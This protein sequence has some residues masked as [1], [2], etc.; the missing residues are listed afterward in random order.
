M[1][2][3]PVLIQV[4][5]TK[6]VYITEDTHVDKRILFC[7]IQQDNKNNN[8][9]NNNKNKLHEHVFLILYYCVSV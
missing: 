9:N 3:P 2:F 6:T 4:S 1:T 5:Y 7:I 8:N